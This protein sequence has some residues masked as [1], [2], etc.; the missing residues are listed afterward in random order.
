MLYS[1]SHV[2]DYRSVVSL[3][4]T[5]TLLRSVADAEAIWRPLLKRDFKAAAALFQ[6]PDRQEDVNAA[7]EAESMEHRWAFSR[8]KA[9]NMASKAHL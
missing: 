8:H 1:C 3:G 4:S 6:P 2:A 7:E 9:F 5:C